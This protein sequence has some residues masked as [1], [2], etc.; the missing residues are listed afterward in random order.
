MVG[1]VFFFS[2]QL[3]SSTQT[4]THTPA[5]HRTSASS[6]WMMNENVPRMNFLSDTQLHNSS[7]ASKKKKSFHI[8]FFFFCCLMYVKRMREQMILSCISM[9]ISSLTPTLCGCSTIYAG[10]KRSFQP[11][12]ANFTWLWIM[13]WERIR[14]MPYSCSLISQIGSPFFPATTDDAV[15]STFLWIRFNFSLRGVIPFVWKR[16][17]QHNVKTFNQFWWWINPFTSHLV[18]LS[19]E[20]FF[21]LACVCLVRPLHQ[22]KKTSCCWRLKTIC[23]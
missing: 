20:P 2:T 16:E 3:P 9:V 13:C 22:Q 21:C 5:N 4:T 17:Q 1:S 23:N 7:R 11:A 6:V 15:F 12:A 14:N 18:T 10:V 8:I 19:A